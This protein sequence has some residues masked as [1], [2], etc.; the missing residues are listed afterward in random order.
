MKEKCPC[1]GPLCGDQTHAE[2]F[3]AMKAR[4]LGNNIDEYYL[5]Q[6][7]LKWKKIGAS[8]R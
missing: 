3:E 7:H 1:P 5:K 6:I 4:Y 8:V 2:M